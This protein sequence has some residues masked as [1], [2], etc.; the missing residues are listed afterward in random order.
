MWLSTQSV[1][2]LDSYS[3]LFLL[4]RLIGWISRILCRC[5]ALRRPK[6]HLHCYIKWTHL[7]VDSSQSAR[8]KV[9]FKGRHRHQ[10]FRHW[11]SW[12]FSN[13]QVN[14]EILEVIP[15][16]LEWIIVILEILQIHNHLKQYELNMNRGMDKS[17]RSDGKKA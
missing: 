4:S 11:N 8:G 10:H 13:L 15:V 12:R 7:T 5:M 2:S 16:T 14:N 17:W 6:Q 9:R 3:L 1:R